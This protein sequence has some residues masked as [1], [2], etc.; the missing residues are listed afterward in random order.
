M[1]K[2][3]LLSM[4]SLGKARRTNVAAPHHVKHSHFNTGLSRALTEKHTELRTD[5][6]ETHTG[7]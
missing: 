5:S 3:A 7:K 4:M 6:E 1:S 2:V